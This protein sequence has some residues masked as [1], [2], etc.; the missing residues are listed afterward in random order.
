MRGWRIGLLGLAVS[1]IAIYFILSQIDLAATWEALRSARWVY[2]L[3]CAVLIAIGLFTRAL[4]WR[5]LLDGVLPLN[6]AFHIL[7]VAYLANGVL[8]LRLGE[9][10]RAYLASRADAQA[11]IPLVLGTVVVERLLDLLSVLGL[12]ALA[13][14]VALPG[15]LGAAA[16]AV[17]PL[18]F[19][20]LIVLVIAA[21]RRDLALRSV[22][23]IAARVPLLRR[24]DIAHLLDDFLKGL[25]PL[26]QPAAFASIVGWS[27]VSW[28]FSIAAGYVI[29][30]AFYPQG[31]W[32]ASALFIAAASLAIAVP[33]APGSLGAYEASIVLALG[34]FAAYGTPVETAAAFAL[35]V[36]GLNLFMYAALGALGLLREGITLGQL[37]RGVSE[38][39]EQKAN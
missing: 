7:N 22:A 8:P 21:T 34:A 33:A 28:F 26:T 37:A 32:A 13:A 23:W 39:R 29:M 20:G 12:I 31:D 36:H 17:A 9:L 30:L 14:S 5:A 3:P 27:V 16:L 6:R 4:R 15:E 38:A 1:V 11:S 35:V 25:A 19:I 10:A 24:L 2:A 18:S